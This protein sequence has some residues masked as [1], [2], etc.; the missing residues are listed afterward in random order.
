MISV[1]CRAAV[2]WSGMRVRFAS[3]DGGKFQF[4]YGEKGRQREGST[5]LLLLHGF[6]SDIF[7]WTPVVQ[8]HSFIILVSSH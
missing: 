6:S 8:V 1:G 4:C 5:S 3:P 2:M 7:M